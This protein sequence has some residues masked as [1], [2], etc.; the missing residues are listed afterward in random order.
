MRKQL[1]FTFLVLTVFNSFS[2][3][4]T[5][6]LLDTNNEPI[7][8]AT[9]KTGAHKGVI[10]NE[11]GV[12]TITTDKIDNNSIEISCLGFKTIKLSLEEIKSK[13][14]IIVLEEYINELNQVFV[15]NGTINALDIIN[16][17]NQNLSKNYKNSDQ[18]YKLFFRKSSNVNFDR[19][20]TDIKKASG[21]R[22]KD[23]A[24]ANLSLDSLNR[25]IINSNTIHFK[26]YLADLHVKNNASAKLDIYKITS[27]LDKKKNFSI[28]NVQNKAQTIILKYLDTT[29][30]YKL[31]T[32]IIKIE[33]SLDLK[34]SKEKDTVDTYDI[35]SLKDDTF[36]LLKSSQNYDETLLKSIINPDNYKYEFE[37][38]T[39]FNNEL[40]YIIKYKPR[41]SRSKYSG[42]L[43]IADESFAILKLDYGFAKGKR[44]EKLNLKLLLG[45]KYEE[46]LKRG[47]IIFNRSDD[48]TYHPQYIREENGNFFYIN[49]SLK[50]I[51]N[52]LA[53]NKVTFEFLIEGG[54][55][56]KSEMFIIST[57]DLNSAAYSSFKEKEKIKFQKLAEYDPNIWK[58]YHAIEPLEEMKQFKSSED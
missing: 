31:K 14:N 15:S 44:G 19:L 37:G 22:K 12:F 13:H 53:R 41:R 27:L 33:D 47:T 30:T 32:G 40:V 55:R 51:E 49:R 56:D 7:P 43:Y 39:G 48:G 4:V 36:E 18:T 38:T 9:I 6:K 52:S 1:F 28:E 35:A 10:S 2:Q 20:N 5:A 24:N 29:K 42:K 25:A 23:L 45:I 8:F 26:D 34:S 16:K 46:N 54:M 58:A 21:I 50:F 11:E 3:S 17:A 57:S